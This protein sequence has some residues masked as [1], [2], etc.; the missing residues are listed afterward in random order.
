MDDFD[1]DILEDLIGDAD[2]GLVSKLADD[3]SLHLLL[4]LTCIPCSG[5]G[6]PSMLTQL[7]LAGLSQ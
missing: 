6:W 3:P 4:W 5:K 1:D 7:S 2:P